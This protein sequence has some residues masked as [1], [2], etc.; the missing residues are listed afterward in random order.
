MH[1]LPGDSSP[2]PDNGTSERAVDIAPTCRPVPVTGGKMPWTVKST[3]FIES[4]GIS[5]DEA[6]SSHHIPHNT[7]RSLE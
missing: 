5:D 7:L 2:A 1:S 3:R 6:V 4:T